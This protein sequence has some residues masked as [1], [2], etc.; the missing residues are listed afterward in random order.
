MVFSVYACVS[1]LFM[2]RR[3]TTQKT[4]VPGPGRIC[5]SKSGREYEKN[6]IPCNPNT[7]AVKSCDV[8][9]YL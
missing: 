5:N 1:L 4:F 8:V 6:H 2:S 7:F 3:P 9:V